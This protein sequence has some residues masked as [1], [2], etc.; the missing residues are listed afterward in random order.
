ML[1][2]M[3]IGNKGEETVINLFNHCDIKAEKENDKDKRYDHD[4]NCMIGKKKFTCEVKFDA[5]ACDTGNLAIEYW[6]SRKD[7]PSGLMVTKATAWVHLIK[8]GDNI[9]VWIV[10]T[11][12]LK[13]YINENE[14]FKK[15]ENIGDGN[16]NILLY[17]MD[18]ILSVFDRID[19]V[20]DS[21][22]QK[23]VR[24]VINVK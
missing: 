11:N 12:E 13:K 19:N 10:N 17:K 6:N 24:K 22:V 23:I 20:S 1:K 9:T 7:K 14:P 15:L 18:D 5:M 8:D 16:S 3:R 2:S 4:I 21:E